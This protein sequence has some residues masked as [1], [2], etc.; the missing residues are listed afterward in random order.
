MDP[1]NFSTLGYALQDTSDDSSTSTATSDISLKSTGHCR[2]RQLERHISRHD[3][4]KLNKHG[5]IALIPEGIR[6][7]ERSNTMVWWQSYRI[8]TLS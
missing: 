7:V 3:L 1:F 4:Q 5:V 6:V 2:D 8:E